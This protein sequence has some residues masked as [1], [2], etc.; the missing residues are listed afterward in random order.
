MTEHSFR[1]GRHQ[2]AHQ[3]LI[4]SHPELKIRIHHLY[5]IAITMILY[6]ELRRTKSGSEKKS[7]KIMSSNRWKH[8]RTPIRVVT[9]IKMKSQ[10]SKS[11]RK[12][13]LRTMSCNWNRGRE[14]RPRAGA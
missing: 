13:K 5:W 14:Q 7:I 6:N 3:E 10:R 4:R 12:R 1:Y 2:P 8:L 11:S 9:S